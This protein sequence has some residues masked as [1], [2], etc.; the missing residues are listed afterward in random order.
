LKAYSAFKGDKEN[1]EMANLLT[2]QLINSLTKF[3]SL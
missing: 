2:H 3:L 1:E